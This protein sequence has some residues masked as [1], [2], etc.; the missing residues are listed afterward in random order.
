MMKNIPCLMA[1]T[2][3]L[4]LTPL[5]S[6]TTSACYAADGSELP[7]EFLDA[8]PANQLYMAYAEFKMGHHERAHQMWVSIGGSGRSEALFN[9]ANLYTQGIGVTKDPERGVALYREAAEAGSRAAAYQLGLFYLHSSPSNPDEAR[10]WLTVAALDG[11]SD[12][13]TL[14]AS[15]QKNDPE[16]PL[17]RVALLLINDNADQ[18]LALLHDLATATP[19]DYRA[20]TRLAWL[21]ETGLAV[22]RDLNHAAG[23]FRQ[24]AE[25]GNAEAQ[26]ALSVM[27]RTGA[28]QVQNSQ[29]A[30]VWLRRAAAQHYQPA[31]DKL[32]GTTE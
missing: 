15:L 9:L 4:S 27:Y 1:F 25:A 28:G 26:Y 11:D 5:L 13:A 8:R 3:L 12:A 17:S 32:S 10:H 31:L 22:E 19:P 29:L 23:L 18:A 14:L 21:Y 7:A 30:D 24:A 6:L 2:A 20:V 16:D